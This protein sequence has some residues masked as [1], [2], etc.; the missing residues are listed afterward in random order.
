MNLLDVMRS[1]LGVQEVPGDGNNPIIVGWFEKIGHPEVKD[2]AT[3]WCACCLSSALIE[4]GLP[5]TPRDVCMMARS[6]LSYGVASPPAPGAIAIWPRGTG[7]QGH[8]NVVESVAPDGFVICIGGN[9]GGLAGGDAV[10][11]TKPMDPSKALG[12]RMPVK[13]SVKDLRKAGSTEIKSGDRVQNIGTAA[14]VV[15]PVVAAVKDILDPVTQVPPLSSPA[16]AFTWWQHTMEGANAVAKIVLQNPWLA[17]VVFVGIGA[18]WVGHTIKKN[19]VAKA[20]AGVPLSTQ[21]G[22]A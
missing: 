9:Q 16:E 15:G 8:V 2:D 11:R 10:T 18:A 4:C 22:A 7:W 21:V 6:Y 3:A 19:R 5:S 1:R 13:A 12:F 17:S 14:V 20:E